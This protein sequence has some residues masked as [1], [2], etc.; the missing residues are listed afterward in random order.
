MR[1]Y[2]KIVVQTLQ[3]SVERNFCQE[4]II[5]ISKEDFSRENVILITVLQAQP[6][7]I[8]ALSKHFPYNALARW[9]QA[10]PTALYQHSDVWCRA[11][12]PPWPQAQAAPSCKLTLSPRR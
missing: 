12:A 2:I 11:V 10:L 9:V 8:H 1:G 6:H 5:L 7:A 4:T 3:S